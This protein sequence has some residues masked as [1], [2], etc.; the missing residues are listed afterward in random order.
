L[1][2][3]GRGFPPS[4]CAGVALRWFSFASGAAILTGGFCGGRTVCGVVK[5]CC[6]WQMAGLYTCC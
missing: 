1:C 2:S 6:Y 3:V 4:F 5:V